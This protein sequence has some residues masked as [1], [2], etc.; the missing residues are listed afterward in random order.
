MSVGNILKSEYGRCCCVLCA[1]I[2]HITNS[3][4]PVTH[5]YCTMEGSQSSS[6][7]SHL[8]R[9][10]PDL[11]FLLQSPCMFLPLSACC[12]G[13]N[14]YLLPRESVCSWAWV[15]HLDVSVSVCVIICVSIIN[16]WVCVSVSVS[17]VAAHVCW[18]CVYVCTVCIS[19]C[20]CCLSLPKALLGV[21]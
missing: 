7:W 18:L 19:M 10:R 8:T 14:L 3:E 20:H 1:Q 9:G 11:N 4:L 21:H 6:P 15:F 2:V 17:G 12:M 16:C 5:Q 13:L